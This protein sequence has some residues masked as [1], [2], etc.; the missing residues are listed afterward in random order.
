MLDFYLRRGAINTRF[1]VLNE[2]IEES[3][4]QLA[5][6]PTVHLLAREDAA[7]HRR[8]E[9]DFRMLVERLGGRTLRF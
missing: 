2:N 9:D 5:L 4:Q 7:D 8:D 6:P 1:L 3:R